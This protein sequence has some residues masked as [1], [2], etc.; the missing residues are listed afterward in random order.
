MFT[1]HVLPA[2]FAATLAVP[3]MAATL[4]ITGSPGAGFVTIELDGSTNVVAPGT[5][6]GLSANTFRNTPEAQDS[7]ELVDFIIGTKPD[8]T[9]FDDDIF[10]V[11]ND[12]NDPLTISFGAQSAVVDGIFLDNDPAANANALPYDDFGFRSSAGLDYDTSGSL[13]EF[14]GKG[15]IPLDISI[16]RDGLDETAAFSTDAFARN[17]MQVTINSVPVSAVPVPPALPALMVGLGALAAVARRR[18]R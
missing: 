3:A 12:A 7:F 9:D 2:V 13:L 8:G 18:A 16:F 17:E 14:S 15:T 10:L 6:R 4:S 1:R 5:I 11:S